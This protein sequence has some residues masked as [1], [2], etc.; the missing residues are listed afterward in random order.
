LS[1]TLEEHNMD[2]KEKNKRTFYGRENQISICQ[3]LPFSFL[4]DNILLFTP[5]EMNAAPGQ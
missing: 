1:D 2:R 3:K 4:Q 5:K